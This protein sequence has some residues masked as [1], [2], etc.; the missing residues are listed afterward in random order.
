MKKKPLP[1]LSLLFWAFL[2]IFSAVSFP[3]TA[4][5]L[6]D[7]ADWKQFVGS[8]ANPLLRDTFRLQTFAQS[9]AG[10]WSYT[11]EGSSAIFNAAEAGIANQGGGYS[12][13]MEPGSLVRFPA[14]TPAG[15]TDVQIHFRYAA[16]TLMK[17][18]N[19]LL[20]TTRPENSLADYP[21]CVV[22]SDRYTLSYPIA[23]AKN[24]VQIGGDP[25][26]L[27][28]R[29][30]TAGRTAGGFYCLDSVYAHG[31]APRYSLFTGAGRWEETGRW[32]H[33]I[34]GRGRDA[35][36]Q[37][38]LKIEQTVDCRELAL[39]GGEIE[40][41]G[42]A[43]LN[44]RHLSM[45]ADGTKGLPA[46]GMPTADAVATGFLYS[47]GEINLSGV[48]T[49][50]QTF[51]DTGQWYLI[52]FPFDVYPDGVDPSFTWKDDAPNGGGN[53]F[54]VRRYDSRKR[55]E[56]LLSTG[57]WE[58]MSPDNHKAGNPL[59]EKNTGY[60][61][62]L[63]SHSDRTTLS[64]SSRPGEIPPDFGQ[65]GQIVLHVYP[66]AGKSKKEAEQH[67][68][69]CLCGNPFP[70]PLR[71]SHL[72]ADPA[73]YEPFVYVYDGRGYQ[74]YA[75][76]SDYQLPPFSAFFLKANQNTVLTWTQAAAP[77]PAQQAIAFTPALKNLV[78]EP[79]QS[80][81]I[82]T[83]TTEISG[84]TP[85]IDLSDNWL[86]L[87]GMPSAGEVHLYTADGRLL[88][89]ASFVGGSSRLRLPVSATTGRFAI[90]T[91]RAA[92]FQKSYKYRSRP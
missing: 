69:W 6:P 5:S 37:G 73:A 40:I 16:K 22:S 25:T 1:Y 47:W 53:Y 30:A 74:A 23:Y 79:E 78:T 7:P 8:P 36:V 90:L 52:S 61:I 71:L 64:F 48:F 46:N 63:D 49:L 17:G 28:L 43:R 31:L 80:K 50:E 4:Q 24:H 13:K 27:V 85:E 45:Y 32:S 77:T 11:T 88:Y 35:L 81:E 2:S 87:H 62:A 33:G 68:G 58:V 60:L 92:G 38:K 21:V 39:G 89:T 18:E 83:S 42:G 82:P 9:E 57:N 19:L 59:F 75:L 91:V 54:Y 34:P 65:K 56:T 41:E 55:A 44:L 67:T 10:N 86:R 26:D 84:L 12:L 70:A 14:Y 76:G 20:S 3:A 66:P 51:A 29:V 15:H 72:S